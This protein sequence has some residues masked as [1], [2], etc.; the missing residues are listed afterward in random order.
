VLTDPEPFPGPLVA[1]ATGL[2]HVTHD[3]CLILAADMPVLSATVC[4][5][6]VDTLV[7]DA[8]KNVVA[9]GEQGEPQP[10][11]SVLRA[12][13]AYPYLARIVASG[14]RRLRALIEMPGTSVL[15]ERVWRELDPL[16]DSVRDVDTPA[17]YLELLARSV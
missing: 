1:L 17:D 10:L 2:V 15:D 11:P 9:L 6:L 4:R 16:R 14:E 7:A 13:S 3:V 5:M 12:R 8:A